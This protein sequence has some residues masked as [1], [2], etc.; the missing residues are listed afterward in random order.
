MGPKE[1]DTGKEY[2]DDLS[3]IYGRVEEEDDEDD[4][5]EEEEC[6]G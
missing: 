1:R 6:S 3:T 4:E 5:E 2:E